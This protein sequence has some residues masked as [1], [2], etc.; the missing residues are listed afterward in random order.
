LPSAK[1]GI[2]W[3]QAKEWLLRRPAL[4]CSK[5]YTAGHANGQKKTK[6]A[7]KLGNETIRTVQIRLFFFV[8]IY[9]DV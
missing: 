4:G 6:V 8:F 1:S 7:E 3:L 5:D 9:N 2:S